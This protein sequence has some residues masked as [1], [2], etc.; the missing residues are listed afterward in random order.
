[1]TPSIQEPRFDKQMV[2]RGNL[3]S[4]GA[5]TKTN[6]RGITPIQNFGRNGD[7]HQRS[8]SRQENF[9]DKIKRG[10]I[11]VMKGFKATKIDLID[12]NVFDKRSSSVLNTN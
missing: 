8:R 3:A 2:L 12:Q 10:S 1:M 11:S 6:F 5:L 4:G 9:V 7:N